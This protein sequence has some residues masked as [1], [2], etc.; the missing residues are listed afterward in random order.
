MILLKGY[1]TPDVQVAIIRK[2]RELGVGPGGFYTPEYPGGAKMKLRMMCLGKDWNPYIKT[3]HESRAHDGT[4]VPAIPEEFRPL[5]KDAIRIAQQQEEEPIPDME[6]DICIVNFYEQ[7]GRLG[8][9]QDKDESPESLTRGI[10]VV[11]WS[12][13]DDAEF[14]F[15][16]RKRMDLA[17]K[18]VLKSGDVLIMGGGSRMLYHGIKRVRLNTAPLFVIN[19]THM[20][21][22]RLNLTFRQY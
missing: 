17:N 12:I 19:A 21:I 9:H 16:D 3:Y 15:G 11:S 10:P 2:C 18:I 4:T 8:L 22:G 5:V 6:A 14:L 1:L 7:G 13:G 20:R